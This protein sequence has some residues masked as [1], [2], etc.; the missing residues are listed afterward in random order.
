MRKIPGFPCRFL[1]FLRFKVLTPAAGSDIL[2][3]QTIAWFP[4][5]WTSGS[6]RG[7]TGGLRNANTDLRHSG[8]RYS[9][10]SRRPPSFTA[11]IPRRW[12]DRYLR[13][14][15][16]IICRNYIQF[17]VLIWRKMR[18]I[19]GFPCR[20]LS[21]L[22]FKVLTPAAGSDILLLQTIAWFPR[23][24]TSGSQRGL[25]GGLR[26]AN[27]DLRHSGCRYSAYSRRP[28]SFTAQ[29]PRRWPDRYLR[30]FLCIICRNYIHF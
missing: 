7:L 21:F 14:F 27:T 26:N 9:A 25:T 3:L 8:C 15:L 24:W 16:C 28:P 19:P 22:R 1:S 20:F 23:N 5:N 12:P 10:Y 17:Q 13:S 11:Q 18:K 6:Q 4:R 29:I 30:S 2:L